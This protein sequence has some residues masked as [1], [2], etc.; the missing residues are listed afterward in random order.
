MTN[1]TESPKYL[2]SLDLGCRFHDHRTIAEARYHG[3]ARSRTLESSAECLPLN[4]YGLEKGNDGSEQ[5]G[6]GF[7]NVYRSKAYLKRNVQYLHAPKIRPSLLNSTLPTLKP[8]HYLPHPLHIHL[9]LLVSQIPRD[10]PVRFILNNIK[11]IP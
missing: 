2:R 1:E 11:P 4:A 10:I 9:L 3:M 6:S 8:L 7:N 5:E